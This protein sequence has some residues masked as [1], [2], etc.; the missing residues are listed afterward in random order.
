[1]S[2]EIVILNVT[3]MK[4]VGTHTC[5]SDEDAQNALVSLCQQEFPD[6]V[7]ELTLSTLIPSIMIIF[8]PLCAHVTRHMP[9][10]WG[11]RSSTEL[12]AEYRCLRTGRKCLENE[13]ILANNTI[14]T[15]I[16]DANERDITIANLQSCITESDK[17]ITCAQSNISSKNNL[18]KLLKLE[19]DTLTTSSDSDQRQIVRL[20][21]DRNSFQKQLACKFREIMPEDVRQIPTPSP[22]PMPTP[23]NSWGSCIDEITNF[24]LSKLKSRT[25]RDRKLGL[26]TTIEDFKY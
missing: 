8:S 11:W 24:N 19:V 2:F 5:T 26:T 13:L 21:A 3:A 25:E 1:M 6:A 17:L 7:S 9:T 15:L 23:N 18:I 10:G 12:L 16:N 14:S 22:T 20:T 4:I